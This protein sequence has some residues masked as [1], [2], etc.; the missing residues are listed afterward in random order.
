MAWQHVRD[1]LQPNRG[2]IERQGRKGGM[3]AKGVGGGGWGVWQAQRFYLFAKL[4]LYRTGPKGNI[5]QST[6][7]C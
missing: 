7:P 1:I 5:A 3:Q 6:T 2:A 4:R